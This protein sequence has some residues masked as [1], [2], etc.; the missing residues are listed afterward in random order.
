MAH[1]T[2]RI[3]DSAREILREMAHVEGRPMQALLDD[4]NETFRRKRFSEEINAAY[5]TLRG[6]AARGRPQDEIGGP[7]RGHP[8][9]LIGSPDP[10]MGCRR[11]SDAGDDRGSPTDP[12]ASV[13]PAPAGCRHPLAAPATISGWSASAWGTCTR[14]RSRWP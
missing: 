10:E 6:L 12:A 11:P 14:S 9:D 2:V 7:L 3:S 13:I 4:A 8:L 1:T 5:A